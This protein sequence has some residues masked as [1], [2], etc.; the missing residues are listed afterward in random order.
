MSL[1]PC[2]PRSWLNPNHNLV[3]SS[4]TTE[5]LILKAFPRQGLI[6]CKNIYCETF[7]RCRRPN[8]RIQFIPFIDSSRNKKVLEIFKSAR[9]QMSVKI[10][11]CLAAVHYK[12]RKTD[13]L[14]KHYRVCTIFSTYH[15]LLLLLPHYIELIQFLATE[16][17]VCIK[18][19]M[20]GFVKCLW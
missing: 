1:K 7:I 5:S 3:N 20:Q 12:C 17:L 11:C 16:R 9:I 6:T 15:L 8:V 18:V 19:L 13:H 2:L 4:I 10:S 14:K